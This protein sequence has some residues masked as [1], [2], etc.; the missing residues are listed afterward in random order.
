MYLMDYI[1]KLKFASIC[2]IDCETECS[3]YLA[4]C[5]DNEVLR[6]QLALILLKDSNRWPEIRCDGCKGEQ[7]ICWRP[8]CPVKACATS[9]GLEFCIQCQDYPCANLTKMKEK[10]KILKTGYN[11]VN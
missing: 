3:I 7:A 5:N 1:N 4:Y 6:R 9:H 11:L 8:H 2:G 10:N